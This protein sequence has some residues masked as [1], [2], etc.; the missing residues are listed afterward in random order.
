MTDREVYIQ[1]ARKINRKSLYSCN[2]IYHP[3]L[4]NNP[5]TVEQRTRYRAAFGFGPDMRRVDGT[6]EHVL[7]HDSFIDQFPEGPEGMALR[8]WCLLMMA[9]ACDDL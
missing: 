2:A 9:A 3:R 4:K 5:G 8:V 7:Q 6:V 1:A